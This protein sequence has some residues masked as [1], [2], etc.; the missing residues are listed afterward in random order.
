MEV[1][2]MHRRLLRGEAWRWYLVDMGIQLSVSTAVLG[3]TRIMISSNASGVPLL[4]AVALASLLALC[5]SII[6]MPD[7]RSIAAA[8]LQQ[9]RFRLIQGRTAP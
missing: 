4:A 8:Q 1:P 6:A 2:I 3:L 9:L 5:L 7:M